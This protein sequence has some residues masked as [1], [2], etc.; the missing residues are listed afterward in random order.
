MALPWVDF[1]WT[2]KQW[3]RKYPLSFVNGLP[4]TLPPSGAYTITDEDYSLVNT[5]DAGPDFDVADF[6][7]ADFSTG[8]GSVTWTMFTPVGYANHVIKIKHRASG[9]LEVAGTI[10]TDEPITSLVLTTGDMV[11][12]RSDGTY[13]N[14]GD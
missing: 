8:S 14:V 6:S 3:I 5:N 13:W 2:I 12:L 9:E 10:F 7:A 4:S 1:V 11:T